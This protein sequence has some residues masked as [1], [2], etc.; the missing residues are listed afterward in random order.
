MI[1]G[2]DELDDYFSPYRSF[3][4]GS[5]LQTILGKKLSFALSNALTKY[6]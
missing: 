5:A 1:D 3:P 4:I 6:W 2:N